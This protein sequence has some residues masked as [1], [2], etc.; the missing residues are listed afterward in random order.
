M[1]HARVS[2]EYIHFAL[3]YMTDHIFP[4]LPIKQLV[5]QNGERTTPQKL[6]TGTKFSGSK[7]CVL[8]CTCVL[9]KATAHV[10]TKAFNMIHQS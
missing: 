5:N 8:L 6:A 10:E 4:I 9:Q 7:L 2:D 1:V 3:M